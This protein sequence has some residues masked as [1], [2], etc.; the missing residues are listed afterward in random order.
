MSTQAARDQPGLTRIARQTLAAP[1]ANRREVIGKRRR[2]DA[3]FDQTLDAALSFAPRPL[4]APYVEPAD[5]LG[6]LSLIRQDWGLT[7]LAD[8]GLAGVLVW[9]PMALLL[10]SLALIILVRALDG[11]RAARALPAH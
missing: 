6:L 4:Y 2:A 5:P 1:R 11:P 8:Q 3:G 10:S 7:V 9:I